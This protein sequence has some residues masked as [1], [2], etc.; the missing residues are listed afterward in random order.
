MPRSAAMRLILAAVLVVLPPATG[1]A[2]APD[3]SPLGDSFSAGGRPPLS[4]R[5]EK[6]DPVRCFDHAMRE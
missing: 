5:V 6:S 1:Q 3:Q 2:Q 4:G